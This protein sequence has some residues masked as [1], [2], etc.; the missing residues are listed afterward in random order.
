M[1]ENLEKAKEANFNIR[2]QIRQ[3]MGE[4]LNDL[5]YQE[6]VHLIE[7]IDA[8]LKLIRERKYKVLG[9][10]IDTSKKKFRNAEEVHR[11]LVLDFDARQDDP[12][13]GLVE[14]GGGGGGPRMAAVH[15]R[16][17]RLHCGSGGT[18]DLTT[19]ALIE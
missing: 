11:K 12:H 14:N 16:D 1:Q 10:Q 17:H 5:G 2:K 4:C 7:N 13:Y 18:S 19:F 3:R 9:N 8:A 15:M 6:M